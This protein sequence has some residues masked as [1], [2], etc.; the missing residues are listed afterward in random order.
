M[1]P[2]PMAKGRRKFL[3]VAINYFT[4]WVKEEPLVNI[5]LAKIY[6][7]IWKKNIKCRFGILGV[8]VMDN[9]K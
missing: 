2:L 9:E 1:G 7:F 5:T 3:L 4:K 6:G 8:M